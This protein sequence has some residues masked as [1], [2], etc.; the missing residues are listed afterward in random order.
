MQEFSKIPVLYNKLHTIKEPGGL[1]I[2]AGL[3]F[4][5]RQKQ[6]VFAVNF[7]ALR[8]ALISTSSN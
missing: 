4:G 7:K 2:A 5:P 3:C 6:R 8:L 1:D